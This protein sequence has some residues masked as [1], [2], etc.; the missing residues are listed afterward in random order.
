MMDSCGL[1]IYI[2]MNVQIRYFPLVYHLQSSIWRLTDSLTIWQSY[3]LMEYKQWA[4]HI[5]RPFRCLS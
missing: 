4:I 2:D 5:C 1:T 3:L